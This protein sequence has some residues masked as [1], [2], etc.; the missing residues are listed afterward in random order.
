[1]N[2]DVTGADN[3]SFTVTVEG[4]GHPV[5]VLHPGSSDADSWARVSDRLADHLRVFRF[6]RFIYR[7]VPD[8]GSGAMEAEVA[9]L[10][11][12]VDS[13]DEPPVI[14][15]HS[16]GAVVA[17][18]AARTAG[19]RLAGLVLYDPP[20]AVQEPL[21]GGALEEARAA[22]DAGEPG[23][24]VAIFLSDIGRFPKA[25]VILLQLIPPL[26]RK[27]RAYAAAQIADTEA[28]ESLGVGLDRYHGIDLP[29]LL[30]TGTLSP[31][32]LRSSIEALSR[33]LPTVDS[34][35]TI[36]RGGHGMHLSCPGTLADAI[37]AFADR[38]FRWPSGEQ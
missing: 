5:V 15:G 2:F 31:R 11:A 30:I 14:V 37:R 27:Q 35:V 3:Q 7:H 21:G 19:S 36:H 4:D 18:E 20:L 25:A 9:D 12:V 1:M 13:F 29:V 22:L 8:S 26:W 6:D 34:V 16:S 10:S 38:V 17:L 28:I 32:H 24:A 23:K 33:A